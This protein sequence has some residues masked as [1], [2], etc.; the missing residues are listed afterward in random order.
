M[1]RK[2]RDGTAT[3]KRPLAPAVCGIAEGATATLA[4]LARHSTLLT[5]AKLRLRKPSRRSGGET[6]EPSL[7]SDRVLAIQFQQ[8]QRPQ[9]P[10]CSSTS[11]RA[12]EEG[13]AITRCR[14]AS[15][16]FL[17][18]Q[19]QSELLDEFKASAPLSRACDFGNLD[20]RAAFRLMS[21]AGHGRP[22][23]HGRPTAASGRILALDLGPANGR[24]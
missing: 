19:G 6:F 5:L 24:N 14:P 7:R 22:M 4:P 18:P 8:E 12:V 13:A 21:L 15:P 10:T 2:K 16:P 1:G 20:D 11:P 23:S 3:A 17:L 9:P